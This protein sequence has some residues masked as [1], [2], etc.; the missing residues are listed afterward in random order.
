MHRRVLSSWLWLALALMVA[1]APL[2]AQQSPDTAPAAPHHWSRGHGPVEKLLRH[3]AE[4]NLSA[5]QVARLEEINQRME[6]RNRPLVRQLVEMRREWGPEFRRSRREMTPEQREE[7]H[8]RMKEARPLFE[9]IHEN[10]RAAM[11]EVGEVLNEEQKV[12]VREMVRKAH[13]KHGRGKRGEPGRH[14]GGH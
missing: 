3:R 4:L 8:R 10:N 2:A 7:L 5:A 1:P 14:D 11:R 6:E 9:R 12:M 13:E